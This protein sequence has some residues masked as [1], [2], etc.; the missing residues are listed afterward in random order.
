MSTPVLC[1]G[2]G[3]IGLRIAERLSIRAGVEVIGAVDLRADEIGP[4]LGRDVGQALVD[5]PVSPTIRSIPLHPGGVVVHAT[6]S[7]LAAAVPQIRE[8]VE[9]G[10]NVLSTCEE[11][12]FPSSE[13]AEVT[14]LDAAA[15]AAGVSV[16]GAGINPG[17]LMDS[18]VLVLTA[19]CVAVD[20][21]SVTRVVDT[22][23]RRVPL[24]LKAGVGSSV[25][26]FRRR[27][28]MHELGHVGLRE[29]AEMVCHSLNWSIDSYDET[30]EPVIATDDTNTGIGVVPAGDVIGQRQTVEVRMQGEV[31]LSY[32][33]QMSAGADDLD[34]IDIH[35][36]PGIHQRI[37]GGI[38]GD[39]GTEAIIANLVP[40]V[41][42][43]RPGMLTMADVV[44]IRTMPPAI[45]A[46]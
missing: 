40:V 9:A 37:V 10:W 32:E 31:V 5:I 15:T 22:N 42:A 2:L 18:L 44:P 34:A 28:I 39:L 19:A 16:L 46:A 25:A 14:A 27:A 23:R 43:A 33:L 11:L 8:A 36:L 41:A 1:Y 6:V 21:I 30:I 20:R 17:F 24:Q 45:I 26:D 3:P 13:D 12:A 29:S 38:N 35:G 4:A 7:R